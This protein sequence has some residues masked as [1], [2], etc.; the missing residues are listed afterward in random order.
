M[1]AHFHYVM[2]G[3]TVMAFLGGLHYW[4]P[5]MTGRMYS[6]RWGQMA[7]VIVFIGFNLTFFP[8]FILGGQGMPRRYY[9][10]LD[11]FQ[12]MHVFSTVGSWIIGLEPVYDLAGTCLRRFASPR[13]RPTIPGA[14]QPWSGRLRRRPSRTILKSSRCS[15]ASRTIT[16]PK[17][18][19]H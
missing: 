5:K 16:G 3:G 2:M 19:T 13:T 8:Q 11:Q 10:Y 12:P 15:S 6:E 7:A 14:V 9:N 18:V 4:W 17:A 1:V